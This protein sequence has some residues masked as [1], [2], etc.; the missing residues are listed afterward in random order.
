MVEV[1]THIVTV[2]V[3]ALQV[4]RWREFSF[5]IKFAG[6]EYV[7]AAALLND[8]SGLRIHKI[9]LLVNL[10]ALFINQITFLVL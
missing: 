8:V 1:A 5:L 3:I 2:E 7:L 4:E 10:M 9:T 6:F